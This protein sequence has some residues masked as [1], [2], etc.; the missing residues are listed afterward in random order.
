MVTFE[1]LFDFILISFISFSSGE[2]LG[3]FPYLYMHEAI[4]LSGLLN[5]WNEA[6][7]LEKMCDDLN[8]SFYN[9]PHFFVIP[10]ERHRNDQKSAWIDCYYQDIYFS[11]IFDEVPLTY[12]KNYHRL[13]MNM[14]SL[15]QTNPLEDEILL[16][17]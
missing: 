14:D 2:V 16:A 13:L 17:L 8:E 6:S 4:N 10:I 12:W 7:D 3:M 15:I 5:K 1:I 11:C 9:F